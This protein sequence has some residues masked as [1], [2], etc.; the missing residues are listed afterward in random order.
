MRVRP[1]A[2]FALSFGASLAA[3]ARAAE[4][5]PSGFSVLADAA[6]PNDRFFFVHDGR[7][8]GFLYGYVA[9]TRGYAWQPLRGAG[10]KSDFVTSQLSGELSTAL[11]LADLLVLGA[12]LPTGILEQGAGGFERSPGTAVVGDA[13][14]SLRIAWYERRDRAL[15][16]GTEG[17]FWLPTGSEEALTGDA[18]ARAL[19][20]LAVSGQASSFAYAVNAGWLFR[21]RH[22]LAPGEIG[23][24][25]SLGAA[26]GA[27]LFHDTVQVGPELRAHSASKKLLGAATTPVELLLGVRLRS[28]SVVVGAAAGGGLTDAPGAA[29]FRG[30]LS[31]GFSPDERVLD[32]DFDG[33]D[34]EH[35]ACPAD[36][37]FEPNG[38]PA[39]DRDDDSVPDREDA[40]PAVA[41]LVHVDPKKHGC[42]QGG[43]AR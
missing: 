33:L 25:V 19:P 11:A 31:L 26:A 14:L 1:L 27:L 2:L 37:G 23:P 36:P 39:A 8:R 30:V 18:K 24:G 29:A 9:L 4:P 21:E 43:G 35:D 13:R 5:A 6:P 20:L 38:C 12:S 32:F 3:P 34:D 16:V 40:C 42:P 7:A 15:A 10:P 28:G 41:G 22:D 17:D